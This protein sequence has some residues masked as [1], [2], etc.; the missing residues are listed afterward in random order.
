[1][2]LPGH[3]IG[4]FIYVELNSTTYT[5][6]MTVTYIMI[7]NNG[8]GKVDVFQSEYNGYFMVPDVSLSLE[9]FEMALD[10]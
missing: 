7:A 2:Q 8:K 3:L 1:M 9:K 10:Y 5:W 6:N 4:G